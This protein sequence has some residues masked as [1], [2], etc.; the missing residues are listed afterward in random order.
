MKVKRWRK[1]AIDREE[2]MSVIKETKD[3]R[4]P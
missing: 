1:T 4:G 2:W 3:I